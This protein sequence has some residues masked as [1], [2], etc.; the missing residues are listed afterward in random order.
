MNELELK[1]LQDQITAELKTITGISEELKKEI[2]KKASEA[3]LV[4]LDNKQVQHELK[5]DALQKQY[6]ALELKLKDRKLGGERPTLLGDFKKAYTEKKGDFNRKGGSFEFELKGSPKMYFKTLDEAT[7]LSESVADHEVL[8]PFRT[9]GIE[10][11]PDRQVL[12][13]DAVSRGIVNTTRL[14]WI[15]RSARTDNAASRLQDAT[16]LTSNYTWISN[17]AEVESIGTMVKITSEALEDWDQLE[18]EVRNELF[19][20]LERALENQLFQGSGAA[21]QLDGIITTCGAYASTGLTAKV[22]KANTFDAIMAASNQCAEN[23]YVPNYAFLAPADYAQMIMGKA[24]NSGVYLIPPFIAQNGSY[25][26]GVKVVQS[27]LIPAGQILLGDFSKVTL[28][29]RKGITIRLWDQDS[30]DPEFER[31]TIT[32][33]LRAAVKFPAAHRGNTGA[34]VY[35]AIADILADITAV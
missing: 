4:D 33:N 20:A 28:Y 1:A 5:Y 11:L 6:D 30:T 35:D 10:K 22:V 17:N 18:T 7:E 25:V 9:P 8:I 27:N 21:P 3:R 13:M 19:P 31:K 32:A 16:F 15:E 23:N 14:T 24:D 29:T 2:A 34:F 12:M 26:G